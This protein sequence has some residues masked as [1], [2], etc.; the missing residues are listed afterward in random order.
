[1]AND[2][3]R[4][5][6]AEFYRLGRLAYAA[7]ADIE[8]LRNALEAISMM[9]ETAANPLAEAMRQAALDAIAPK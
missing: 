7:A 1:V 9:R 8:K 6:C 4:P 3:D 2:D 5:P